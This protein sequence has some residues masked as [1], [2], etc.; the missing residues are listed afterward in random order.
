M[1]SLVLKVISRT[2]LPVSLIYS[3]YLLWRGHNEPGGGFVGGLV[4]ASGF[5][6]YALPRGRNALRRL[7]L[8]SPETIAGV[9]VI[10]ALVSGVPALL[11]GQPFLTHQW[12]ETNFGLALGTPLLF[13]SGVYLAVN[14][15]V[16]TFLI[17][18]LEP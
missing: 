9:G 13:D 17:Y 10:L 14:G 11:Y 3:V 18:Y 7:L 8:V 6:V 2:L 4:A 5:V 16:L 15:A 12:T 1:N